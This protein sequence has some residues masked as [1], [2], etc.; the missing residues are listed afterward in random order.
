[1]QLSMCEETETIEQILKS[2]SIHNWS[3]VFKKYL[4][5]TVLSKKWG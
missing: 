2:W 3:Q 1:M 5:P 4:C